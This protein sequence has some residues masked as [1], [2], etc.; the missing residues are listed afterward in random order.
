[1]KR[2]FVS[3]LVAWSFVVA[4]CTST[5]SL[6]IVT[7]SSS[8]NAAFLKSGKAVEEIGSVS[9]ESCRYFLL[10]VAP[11]GNGTFSDAVSHALGEKG[12]DALINVSVT[13]S[14]YGFIP[15]YNIFAYTCTKVEGVAVKFK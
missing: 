10:G 7:R 12:G 14:L 2:R 15:I 6:G 5:G 1:M 11:W 9:G 3:A 4:A 8:D 13:T